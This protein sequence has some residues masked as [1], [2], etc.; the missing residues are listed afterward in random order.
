LRTASTGLAPPLEPLPLLE[1]EL[2]ELFDFEADDFGFAAFLAAFG[3]VVDFDL[4]F[5]VFDLDCGFDFV[6]DFALFDADRFFDWVF[7]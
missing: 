1:R 3:F 5:D 7:V 6:D 4:A 2:L